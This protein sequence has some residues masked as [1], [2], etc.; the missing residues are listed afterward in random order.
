M[1]RLAT[2]IAL[3][4]ACGSSGNAP[5]APIADAAA[6]D[7]F[8][9]V[10]GRYAVRD[11][12]DDPTFMPTVEDRAFMQ[13]AARLHQPD[14]TW[15]PLAVAADGTFAFPIPDSR[16]YRVGLAADGGNEF[17]LQLDTAQLDLAGR[18][19][20]RYER[21]PVPAGTTLAVSLPG[22]PATGTVIIESTGVWAA[23]GRS[24]G[25]N[26]SFSLDWTPAPGL[27]DATKYDRAY[28]TLYTN[29]GTTLPYQTITEWCSTD[30]TMTGGTATPLSCTLSAAEL[31][32]CVHLRAH[33]L[34]EYNRVNGAIPSTI[35]YPNIS[36]SW[37][38]FA[39]GAPS[40][41]PIGYAQIAGAGFSGAPTTDLDR[42]QTMYAQPF[43]GHQTAAVMTVQR[44]RL[45][46]L[47]GTTTG[48]NVSVYTQHWLAAA[49]DCSTITDVA[50]TVAIAGVPVLGST[51]LATDNVHVAIDR[52]RDLDLSWPLAFTGRTDYWVVSLLA[53]NV[54]GTATQLTNVRSWIVTGTHVALDPAL[55]AVG[56]NYIVQLTGY[57]GFPDTGAGDLRTSD[58]A[59]GP[60]ATSTQ[61]SAI[62]QVAN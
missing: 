54:Q 45:V 48:V 38:L 47:P 18:I 29:V 57:Q 56:T 46:Q 11:Q 14:G 51:A 26:A 43:P 36:Y 33:F 60:Y 61:L 27:L 58:Y 10:T 2:P 41:G 4:A 53:V 39:I 28:A 42:D 59:T 49:P 44:Y 31:V 32:Q 3:A 17:E 50:G 7:A 23:L 12:R 13:V 52:S 62:F 22:A 8:A 19:G 1:R 37:N 55:L 5:D 16:T 21:T 24:T 30:V 34:G 9:T 6:I 40:L 35:S 20:S 25:T 15:T